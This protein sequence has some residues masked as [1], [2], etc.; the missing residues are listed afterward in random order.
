MLRRGR[1]WINYRIFMLHV[2]PH[3]TTN[4]RFLLDTTNKGCLLTST[5]MNFRRSDLIGLR[6]EIVYPRQNLDSN[7]KV[8]ER[9]QNSQG[10]RREAH[11]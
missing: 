9:T 3:D 2:D 11:R 8:R 7:K 5:M 4:K 10:K 6:K 1:S